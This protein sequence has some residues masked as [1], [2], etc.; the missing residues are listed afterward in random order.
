MKDIG[1]HL[2]METP[3]NANIAPNKGS[4][5]VETVPVDSL[6]CYQSMNPKMYMGV[7]KG[8]TFLLGCGLPCVVWALLIYSFLTHHFGVENY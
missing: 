8:A 3:T 7:I 5:R 6:R 4:V 1:R 2:M